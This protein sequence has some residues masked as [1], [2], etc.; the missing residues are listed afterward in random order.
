MNAA[1]AAAAAAIAPDEP[2]EVSDSIY[3]EEYSTAS[4]RHT[5]R[6]VILFTGD[7]FDFYQHVA[8]IEE[9]VSN[10][11]WKEADALFSK[12]DR[13]TILNTSMIRL[14][15]GRA[16]FEQ[17]EYRE[18]RKILEELHKRKI[19]K[20]EGTEW[21]STSMWHLQD[22]H[23]LSALT[24]ILTSTSRERPQTWCAAGNC[25]SLLR[26]VS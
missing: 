11:S 18:C 5:Y 9:A 26:Q 1:V 8:Y 4:L 14:Q 17:S 6:S 2:M 20:S 15:L 12:L 25:F 3:N 10:Y 22:T 16:C 21:L 24:Q 23:S 7:F 19:W 13:D